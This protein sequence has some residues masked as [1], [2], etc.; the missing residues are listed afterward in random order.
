MIKLKLEQLK[1]EISRIAKINSPDKVQDEIRDLDRAIN[2]PKIKRVKRGQRV[3]FY[4]IEYYY[5]EK[6]GRGRENTLAALGSMSKK[7]YSE[8]KKEIEALRKSGK[9]KQLKKKLD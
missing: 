1:K 4:E 2:R 6:A 8:N 3:F 9:L 5:D 7:S